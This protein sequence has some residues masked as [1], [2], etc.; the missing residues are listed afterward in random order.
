MGAWLLFSR[1]FRGGIYVL[2]T[3][4]KQA[5]EVKSNAHRAPLA[6]ATEP[7]IRIE[8]VIH[9]CRSGSMWRKSGIGNI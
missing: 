7:N 2:V 8:T 1:S 4:A 5:G 6:V 3:V 9:G